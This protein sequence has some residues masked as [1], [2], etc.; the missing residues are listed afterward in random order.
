MLDTYAADL[1]VSSDGARTAYDLDYRSA[2]LKSIAKAH[3]HGLL[4]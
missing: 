4:K 3:D 1:N 2:M